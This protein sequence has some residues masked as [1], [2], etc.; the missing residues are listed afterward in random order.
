MDNSFAIVMGNGSPTIQITYTLRGSRYGKLDGVTLKSGSVMK[1]LDEKVVMFMRC[2]NE[3]ALKGRIPKNHESVL[4]TVEGK[5][6]LA[7]LVAEAEAALEAEKDRLEALARTL[8]PI[9]LLFENGCDSGDTYRLLWPEGVDFAVISRRREESRKIEDDTRRYLSSIDLKAIAE[10]TGAEPVAASLMTYGGF[11]FGGSGLA[12]I[13]ELVAERKAEAARKKARKETERAKAEAEREA[14]FADLECTVIERGATRSEGID[15]YVLVEVRHRETGETLRFRCR[16]IFDF[17]YVVNPA[18]SP[19][20]GGEPGGIA[21]VD[22]SGQ[23]YWSGPEGRGRPL[24]AFERQ[25]LDY[26]HEFPPS[27]VGKGI[28]M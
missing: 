12:A 17:G 25:A 1:R 2:V 28:R 8:E 4:L 24:T 19:E 15:P 14:R 9:G 10:R 27:G 6:D 3:E 13:L 7:A 20:L 18:Y 16:N 11:R 23:W 21:N 5:P 22:E 26:L